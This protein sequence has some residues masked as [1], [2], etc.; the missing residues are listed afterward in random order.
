MALA[1]IVESIIN[2]QNSVFSTSSYLD[3]EY[4]LDNIYIGVPSVIGKDGVKWV[5][6]V[7]LTDTEDERMKESAS[8]L[9]EII[10][11]ANI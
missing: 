8:I 6:E 9:K 5:L 2:D 10:S 7:P 3:G 4:G 11:K 1:R